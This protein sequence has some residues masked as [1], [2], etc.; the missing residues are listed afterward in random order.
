MQSTVKL[1]KTLS[2]SSA[3]AQNQKQRQSQPQ[4]L[5]SVPANPVEEFATDIASVMKDLGMKA[6]TP[7]PPRMKEQS[8]TG[9]S[10][11]NDSG[12]VDNEEEV[13]DG[14]RAV[15]EID[16]FA[17]EI[18]DVLGS[19]G[20]SAVSRADAGPQNGAAQSTG[21]N[22]SDSA[23]RRGGPTEAPN[24]LLSPLSKLGI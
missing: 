7:H 6:P 11:T 21:G 22:A 16:S 19:L 12:D 17:G 24:Q 13:D 23:G 8:N 4:A 9:R 18:R 14:S 15:R 1:G 5:P 2:A 3:S 20:L 10:S